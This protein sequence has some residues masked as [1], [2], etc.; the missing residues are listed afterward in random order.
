MQAKSITGRNTQEMHLALQESGADFIVKGMLPHTGTC[1]WQKGLTYIIV[2]AEEYL[3][4]SG[5]KSSNPSLPPSPQD[6]A[7]D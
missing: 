6:K 3:R 1:V 7:Q 5:T 4:F 2:F